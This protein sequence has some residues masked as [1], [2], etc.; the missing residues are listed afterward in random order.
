MSR[1]R[2]PALAIL[3]LPLVSSAFPAQSPADAQSLQAQ[4]DWSG[5]E[6]IWRKLVA[7]QPNDFRLWAS[8][9]IVLAHET[10]YPDAIAAY[11]KAL[12][13]KPHD[14]Q[15]EL[16]LGITYFKAGMFAEALAP[17]R[18]A[19]ARFGDTQ[20][21]DL[22]LGMSLF[23]V[24]QYKPASVYL[25]R[26]T[27]REP[28]NVELQRTLAESYLYSAQYPQAMAQFEVLLRRDPDSPV[29]HMLLAEAYDAENQPAKAI[30]EFRAALSKGDFPNGHFSLGYLL[31][32]E[33]RYEEAAAE[34]D[35]ELGKDPQHAQS[36]TYLGDIAL[37]QGDKKQ[38]EDF[39]RRAVA[40][41]TD[42]HLAYLDLGALESEEKLYEAAERDLK[43]SIALD[44]NRADAHYRLARVYQSLGRS[45][46]ADREL[47]LVK[48]LHETT[49]Q[50]LLLKVSGPAKH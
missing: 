45:A 41:H 28:D 16:N 43:H 47:A 44:P 10:R 5:A 9:A 33:R 49:R 13:L 40:L 7:S 3:L 31:W 1:V 15:T 32:K 11:K 50:D 21:T 6:K 22:L 14:K 39:L 27:A 30:E 2:T 36:L 19:V 18:S 12:T 17:L 42:S 20:Q 38:A 26:A 23:G 35:A 25:E 37:T 46:D 48:Q 34:F 24:R 8:L 4:N 29:V